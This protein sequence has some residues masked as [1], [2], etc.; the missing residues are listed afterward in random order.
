M[1]KS[2]NIEQ[3]LSAYEVKGL[4]ANWNDSFL[5]ISRQ[6]PV[7]AG[8]I[9]IH[10]DRSPDI[11]SIPKMQSY[12]V[13]PLGLFYRDELIGIAIASYQKRLI[14]GVITD[15]IYLGNMHVIRKGTGKL[16]LKKLGERVAYKVKKRP[17]VKYLY[18]YVMQDNRPGKRIARLGEL[19]S[20]LCGSISMF[21]LLTLKQIP[22]SSKFLIR[23][24]SLSDAEQIV[25]LLSNAYRQ[26]FLAPTMNLELFMNN[27]EQ[28]PGIDINNYYLALR[29]KK[30][31]GTCLA[32][33]M[34]P[35]K[36]NRIKFHGFKMKFV[37]S[38]YN[39]MA[40]LNGS[41]KL[42]EPGEP[43]RDVTIAE[44]AV[45]NKDPEIM[46]ALLR[47]V[48]QDYRQRG[49]HSIIFGCS[50]EDPIH[51]ATKPFLFREVR[52]GVVIA[53]LQADSIRNF[54]NVSK[55]YADAI[56]I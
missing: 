38:A 36:K 5:E 43:F 14:R 19:D 10:F 35:I 46:E 9:S 34:T 11:L 30:I 24:A 47:A 56:Q 28:R 4:S 29:G 53:P 12:R 31:V 16:F 23:K 18:G 48:Y 3:D 45:L 37:H 20:K 22:L 6:S 17:E 52:S 2:K 54:G 55:I 21:T 13:V 15:V 49:Y 44:Y 42:P 32:W 25:S 27:L 51:K 40:Q 41:A 26:Q 7:R 1:T 50:S 8:K 33:D 39:L